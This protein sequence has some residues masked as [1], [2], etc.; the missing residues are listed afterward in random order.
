MQDQ[1]IDTLPRPKSSNTIKQ[2]T[3]PRFA[4]AI[5]KVKA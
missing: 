3:Q 1:I 5:F 2:R 4:F